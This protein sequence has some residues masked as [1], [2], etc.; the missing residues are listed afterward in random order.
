MSISKQMLTSEKLK[1]GIKL[2]MVTGYNIERDD[3]N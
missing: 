1:N 2:N 3:W